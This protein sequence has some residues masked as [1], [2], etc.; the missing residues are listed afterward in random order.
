MSMTNVE[1]KEEVFKRCKEQ[2]L[3]IKRRK[4]VVL[5]LAPLIFTVCAV[6]TFNLL[7]SLNSSL[8]MNSNTAAEEETD[9]Y[10][11]EEN[12]GA[13]FEYYSQTTAPTTTDDVHTQSFASVVEGCFK[14]PVT[15]EKQGSISGIMD[16]EKSDGIQKVIEDM[17]DS[18]RNEIITDSMTQYDEAVKPDYII[19]LTDKQGRATVYYIIKDTHTNKEKIILCSDKGKVNK[20]ISLIE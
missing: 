12:T 16:K 17:V 15:V 18:K 8:R 11:D 19:T 7:P 10:A 4:R 6:L 2:R 9:D 13:N 3:K 1:F 5:G 14:L 20:L